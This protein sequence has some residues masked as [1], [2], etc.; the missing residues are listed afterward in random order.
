M[1]AVFAALALVAAPPELP[2]WV[3]EQAR[4]EAVS[5]VVIETDQVEGLHGRD[6][7]V[8]RIEGRIVAVERGPH[9]VGERLTLD[10][11][12]IGPDWRPRPGPFPG[13]PE[14]M[15]TDTAS[16]RAWLDADD[17]LV[18]RGYDPLTP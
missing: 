10:V 1:P 5:V 14:A 16:G 2:P 11:S 17:R 12:C 3:Y 18:R 13:Y 15:L 4:R 7:G 8:C 6:S 9:A